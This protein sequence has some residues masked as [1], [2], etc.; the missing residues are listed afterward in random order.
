MQLGA[1]AAK[2]KSVTETRKA[3][4]QSLRTAHGPNGTGHHATC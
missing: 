2:H 4:F 1:P 3:P